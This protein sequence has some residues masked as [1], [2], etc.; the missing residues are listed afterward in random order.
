MGQKGTIGILMHGEDMPFTK[1]GIR[2]DIIMNPHAIPSRMTIG[3][4]VECLVGKAVA[5]EGYDA[6][7]TAFERHDF[8]EARQILLKHGYRDDCT[9][10]LYN[11]M[12][13]DRIKVR[14]VI[15]PTFYQ[16]LKHLVDDKIHSRSRG[17][18]VAMTR[19]PPEG[20]A[21]DGGLRMGEM[22]R[23]ALI[24]YGL[25]FF[26]KEKLMDNSDPYVTYI[27][28]NCG[29]FAQ[30]FDREQ[31]DKLP[32]PDD[33]I[34]CPACQNYNDIHKV[35]MPYAFKLV[36]QELTAMCIAPRLVCK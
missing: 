30:R 2:P 22:E 25:G 33:I 31:N 20:R 24:A 36:L 10:Y 14:I 9:E 18:K 34:Y 15:G 6:D 13:G 23:D 19:Q 16:R 32:S 11:G 4:L 35:K 26:I 12:T 28:G 8:D 7:G 29:M 17:L 3:Q 5:L 1:N 21:R 27:C